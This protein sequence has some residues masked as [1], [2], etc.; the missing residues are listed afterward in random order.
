M[1]PLKSGYIKLN[2]VFLSGM[3]LVVFVL[4]FLFVPDT[5][6]YTLEELDYVFA[7]P[8]RQF[9]TYQVT[10]LCLSKYS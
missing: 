6:G 4:M 3:N 9:I 10:K 1:M 2:I 5:S 8:S 7:V